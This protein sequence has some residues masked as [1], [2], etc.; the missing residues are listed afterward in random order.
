MVDLQWIPGHCGL[1]GNEL[2][3]AEAGRSARLDPGQVP[4]M[5]P[6]SLESG[7][8]AISSEIMDTQPDP[9]GGGRFVRFTKAREA[10][11]RGSAGKRR[12]CSRK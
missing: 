2:A 7:R 6:L 10:S 5:A 4:R 3:N 8:S 9:V 1:S 12:S 11:P